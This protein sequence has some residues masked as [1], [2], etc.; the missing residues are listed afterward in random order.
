MRCAT[1]IGG[2]RVYGVDF[3]VPFL[4]EGRHALSE[5]GF[6][7]RIR[8]QLEEFRKSGTGVGCE[9]Q[10][11]VLVGV[12]IKGVDIDEA[13]VRIL[14]SRFRCGCEVTVSGADSYN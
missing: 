6:G 14:E 8:H 12:K 3:F 1:T 5:F 9:A 7:H 2:W 13:N 4:F 10:S 11:V